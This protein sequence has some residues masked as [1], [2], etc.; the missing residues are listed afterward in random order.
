MKLKTFILPII[1]S[2]FLG[3]LCIVAPPYIFE[4][5]NLINYNAPLFPFIATAIE[6]IQIFKSSIL[7]L[8]AYGLWGYVSDAK[9]FVI[10]PAAILIFP[11]VLLLEI[12]KSPTSHNLWPFELGLYHFLDFPAMVGS[13]IGSKIRSRKQ[14]KVQFLAR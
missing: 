14:H 10:G 6:N 13:F 7:L 8:F 12:L 4:N 3:G 5:E 2:A 1:G 11:L 9:W